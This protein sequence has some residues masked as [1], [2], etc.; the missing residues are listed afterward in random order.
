MDWSS[1]AHLSPADC[2]VPLSA[3]SSARTC[4]VYVRVCAWGGEGGVV[5]V[6]KGCEEG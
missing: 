2:L 6:M 5:W 4:V 3:V 1:D